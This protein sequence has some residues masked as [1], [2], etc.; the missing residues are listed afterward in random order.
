[1][2]PPFF[3]VTGGFLMRE[4]CYYARHGIR[5]NLQKSWNGLYHKGIAK[6]CFDIYK[7]YP[8]DINFQGSNTN[9]NFMK[10]QHYNLLLNNNPLS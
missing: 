10:K 9:I 3:P 5:K 1:M 2:T 7:N 8:R 6:G 4:E